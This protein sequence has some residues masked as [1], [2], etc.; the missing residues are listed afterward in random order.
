MTIIIN[1]I[2]HLNIVCHDKENFIKCFNKLIIINENFENSLKFNTN[3]QLGYVN[4]SP[5][6]FGAGLQITVELK[7]EKLIKMEEFKKIIS[8]MEFDDYKIKNSKITIRNSF[9]LKYLLEENFVSSLFFKIMS[10]VFFENNLTNHNDPYF[11]KLILDE[12]P[13]KSIFQ[14]YN[15]TLDKVRFRVALSQKLNTINKLVKNYNEKPLAPMNFIV[16]D[17][18]QYVCFRNFFKEYYNLSQNYSSKIY[19]Y[20]CLFDNF[21]ILFKDSSKIFRTKV[22]INRNFKE[23]ALC[24]YMENLAKIEE[25]IFEILK[26]YKVI[27]SF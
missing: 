13:E 11:L 10:L 1:A 24:P 12:K 19:T 8:S 6:K 22:E 2:D 18:N 21:K 4:S 26:D 16:S 23:L 14:A 3:S 25:K 5:S 27:E 20:N 17:P 9:K 15:N 7:L